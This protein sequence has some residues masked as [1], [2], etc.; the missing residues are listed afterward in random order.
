[1]RFPK[2]LAA[3]ISAGCLLAACG[4]HAA[5]PASGVPA[6][7]ESTAAPAATPFPLPAGWHAVEPALSGEV[8]LG[9]VGDV[10]LADDWTIMRQFR[11]SGETEYA[12]CF[13]TQLLRE[14]RGV[15]ILMANNE[16][17]V[18]RRGAPLPGKLFTFR[19]A[20]ENLAFW[21]E[22]GADLVSLANNHVA[23]YG[24]EAFLDTLDELALAGI[25]AVGAGR[26]L[27]EAQR[28]QYF[29]VGDRVIA[30]VAATRAEKYVLTPQATQT[31]PGVLYTYEADETVEAI[32]A[33]ARQAD[34]V[35]A[36][37]HWGTE[38][39]TALE[40]AQTELATLY[41]QA[42]ADLIVGAHPH[43]LQGAGW[44]QDTPVFYSLGNFWFNMETKDTGLLKVTLR[45]GQEPRCQF[46]PCLQTGGRTS[47]L[48][49]EER[50]AVLAHMN[51]I[52]EDG[53]LDEEGVF[54]HEASGA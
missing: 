4:S 10:N 37:V 42:G 41:E 16:F 39:T 40:S 22:M 6:P 50:E 9:F 47:L 49:G 15:D 7:P 13:S 26:N 34:F 11:Q 27:A 17:S 23:D 32:R 25:P 44:R 2:A 12:A 48:T 52:L 24:P 38:E 5:S 36:Y 53:Y 19:A 54:W 8:T 35:V 20:P 29:A 46:V 3:L 43:V 28:A 51:A 45:P 31:Q 18:S 1:M 21:Q 33:A 30:F 14:L